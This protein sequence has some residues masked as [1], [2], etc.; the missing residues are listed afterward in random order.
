MC[1]K[2]KKGRLRIMYIPLGRFDGGTKEKGVG[3]PKRSS[4]HGSGG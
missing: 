2:V 4:D 1:E 3:P